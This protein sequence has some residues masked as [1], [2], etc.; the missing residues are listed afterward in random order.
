MQM[1]V[2]L[3]KDF[4]DYYAGLNKTKN[5]HTKNYEYFRKI[6]VTRI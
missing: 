5:T 3:Y 4:Y 1:N 6:L 2:K